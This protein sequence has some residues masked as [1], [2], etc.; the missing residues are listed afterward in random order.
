MRDIHAKFGIPNSPQSSDIG[1]N[2]GRG[3]SH[4][5]IFGQ[6]LINKNC[7]NSRTSNDI[8]MK[9]GQVTKLDKRNRARSI[10]LTMMPCLQILTLLSF[11]QSMASLEQSRSQI[12][13]AWSV[14][15]YLTKTE[16][17]TKKCPTQFSYY[18]FD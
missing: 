12:S 4:F 18:C 14:T 9:L 17:R 15:F 6:S 13:D 11:F 2:S 16:N 10:N 3:I 5:L 7:H 8:D 1:Q